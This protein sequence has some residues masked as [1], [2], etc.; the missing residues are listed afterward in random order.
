MED[1]WS[2]GEIPPRPGLQP[3]RTD[4]ADSP[5]AQA[6]IGKD[7]GP[8]DNAIEYSIVGDLAGGVTNADLMGVFRNPDPG[9]VTIP[10]PGS[11]PPSI[12]AAMQRSWLAR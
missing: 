10:S 11:S 5:L 9:Y 7:L 4:W 12:H 8:V 2:R 3:P 1:K 6:A